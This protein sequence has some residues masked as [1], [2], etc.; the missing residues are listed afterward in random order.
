MIPNGGIVIELGVAAGKFAVQ[1]MQT[2]PM[3]RYI[4]IDRWSD[5]HDG[6]EYS[7]AKAII[8]IMGGRVIRSTFADALPDF[9]DGFADMIYLDG[10]AHTGQEGGQTLDDWYPK[11]RR[12]G[13]FAGHDYHPEYQP[14]IDAVNAFVRKNGLNFSLTEEK[15]YPSW[16]VRKP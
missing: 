2:N 4:G 1:L 8:E 6:E 12:G 13:I 11:L 7:H 9:P 14:T 5:H 3:I 15:K 16:W 10:Y